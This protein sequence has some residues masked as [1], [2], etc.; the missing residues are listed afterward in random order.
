MLSGQ[1]LMKM[2]NT[3]MY[4]ALKQTFRRVFGE[5]PTLLFSAP[6]RTELIG[7]HTDH[8]GGMVLGASIDLET[9]AAVRPM[10]D[11]SIRLL[12][13]GYPMCSVS[14]S[15][16]GVQQEEKGSTAALIRGVAAGF[17]ARGFRPV[18]FE[19]AVSSSVLPGSG[20][21]SSASF[22]VLIGTVLNYLAKAELP[23]LEIAKIGQEAENR[24]Y[25]KPSGLLDQAAAAS[26]G[27]VFL[28]FFPGREVVSETIPVNFRD[29]GYA[30][31]VID[32]GADHADL[33][34][35]YASIPQEL[36]GVAAFFGKKVLREVDEEAFYEKLPEVRAA[37]S[38][39]AVLRAMH[40]YDENRRVLLA[41]AA[42]KA[43]DMDGFFRQLNESGLSSQLLLQ[44]I[45][46][47]GSDTR[48]AL[49]YTIACAKRLL[50]SEGAVRVQGGGFAGTILTFVPLAR[51]DSFCAEMDRVLG[52][53]SC[54][55][56]SVRPVG[57]VLLEEVR[58]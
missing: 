7:N 39:R 49:S 2:E 55:V 18:G 4:Q 50:D 24:F 58:G 29:F 9:A 53:K 44:N 15:D 5:E 20:L 51:L 8:Q 26:G 37:T 11:G 57:G 40:I 21:S 3:G 33:T 31:A 12:S 6:G 43:G 13:E 48:Q 27:I 56:L 17:A 34:A 16:L 52:R 19:A 35:D 28:D 23:A 36:G 32:S 1:K 10:D 41:R 38:D 45:I 22:E 46:P 47:S 14:L 25:G 30:I 42:L 54:H